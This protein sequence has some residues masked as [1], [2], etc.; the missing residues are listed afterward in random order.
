MLGLDVPRELGRRVAAGN[1]ALRQHAF[2]HRGR[3]QCLGGF[4]LDAV[5]DVGGRA[6]RGQQAEPRAGLV[7][8]ERRTAGLFHSGHVRQRWRA[9]GTGHRQRLEL[10]RLDL[11]H[12][13]GQV[14]EHHVHVAAHHVQQG[15]TRAAVGH[16]Q[17]VGAGHAL[18]QFA[19]EV[20]GG[21]VAAGGHV[22]LARMGLGVADEVLHAR[23]ALRARLLGID[24]H[25][26][27]HRGHQ[28]DRHE[29]LDG[30]V[31]Q[32]AVERAVDA[33]GAHGAH[34]QRVAVGWRLGDDLRADVAARAR[35]VVH[36]E[37]LT[38][39]AAQFGRDGPR[40]DV[41]GAAGGEGHDDA[42]GLGRPRV[43]ARGGLPGR[44]RGAREQRAAQGDGAAAEH[45]GFLEGGSGMGTWA[46]GRRCVGGQGHGGWPFGE[47]WIGGPAVRSHVSPL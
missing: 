7:A 19:R 39:G 13:R 37:L 31:G 9:G 25:H 28:R 3:C 2:L 6:R 1:G 27:R 8:F 47:P 11:R 24:F 12:G 5:H 45:G 22:E 40:E 17:H 20:D 23:D 21:A 33:V 42:H 4:Q 30:V 15:R 29:V 46:A 41:G 36:H 14:V 10:A 18:E 32:L 26:V 43:G 44:E 34:E 35:A 38:E 16:V